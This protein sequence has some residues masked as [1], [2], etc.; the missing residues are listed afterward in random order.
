V[1]TMGEKVYGRLN[2]SEIRKIM[3]EFED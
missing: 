3:D 1:A 2:P